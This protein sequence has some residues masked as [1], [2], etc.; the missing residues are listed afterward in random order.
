MPVVK[1]VG[2]SGATPSKQDG[3]DKLLRQHLSVCQRI[4]AKH[5]RWNCQTYQ[6]IDMNAGCGWNDHVDCAGSPLVFLKAADAVKE[7][8]YK[9]SFIEIEPRNAQTLLANIGGPSKSL[10]VC[11]ADNKEELPVLVDNLP[12]RAI[13]LIYTDPNGVPD[14]DLLEEVSKNPKCATMDILIRYTASAHKRNLH[15]K[16]ERLLGCLGRVNKRYWMTREI[17]HG[18]RWQWTFLLGMNWGG[19]SSWKS[20]GFHWAHSD[21]GRNI[22]EKLNYTNGEIAELR[23]P[24]LAYRTYGEY[25]ATPEFKA[26]RAVVFQRA[27]GKCE[28]CHQ[29]PPFD[30]H[31][32][33]YPEWGTVDVP[34][35]LIAVCR[36]CHCELH[37]KE[38]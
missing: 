15:I 27:G 9:A 29:R 1:G 12:P 20:Q 31:H 21:E 10:E 8:S 23:Q 5:P 6:Y 34:E 13:G 25:L 22:L 24:K 7:L 2:Q 14:F 36:E 18:D 17:E 32:L 11:I 26:V 4:I 33:V 38:R 19:M 28:R 37:G 30:A 16:P 35:N 3:L